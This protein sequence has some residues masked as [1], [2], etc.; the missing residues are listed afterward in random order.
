[1]GQELNI[2]S[3]T[4]DNIIE[5]IKELLLKIV[6][7]VADEIGNSFADNIKYWRFKNQLRNLEKVKAKAT[8]K[9]ITLKQINL[10]V[11]FDYLEGVSLEEDNDIQEMWAN[12]LTNYID[13]GKNLKV[14]VYPLILRQVSSNEVNILKFMDLNKG[15]LHLEP[16]K[17]IMEIED[18]E[19]ANLER[20]GLIKKSIISFS[21]FGKRKIKMEATRYNPLN[22][23]FRKYEVADFGY[24][25]LKACS[26]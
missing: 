18:A 3:S 15:A 11:M 4:L 17:E 24:D 14:N 5:P 23:L 1:M 16:T 10:K 6:G 22:D 13:S 20:L 19:L 7:P 12:L 9:G 2:K 26:D 21:G 25:F 8:Q